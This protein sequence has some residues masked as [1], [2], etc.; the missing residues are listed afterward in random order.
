MAM[1]REVTHT[2]DYTGE[3][4]KNVGGRRRGNSQMAWEDGVNLIY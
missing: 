3:R 1:L 2:K 4:R